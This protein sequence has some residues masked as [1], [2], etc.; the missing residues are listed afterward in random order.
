M[1]SMSL[2]RLHLFISYVSFFFLSVTEIVKQSSACSRQKLDPKHAFNV[3]A[4]IPVLLKKFPQ[5]WFVVIIASVLSGNEGVFFITLDKFKAADGDGWIKL[6]A[7]ETTAVGKSKHSDS[8]YRH[9]AKYFHNDLAHWTDYWPTDSLTY[10]LTDSPTHRLTDSLTRWLTD[11]LSQWLTDSMTQWLNESLTHWLA[12]SLTRWL[13]D[14]LTRWLTDSLTRWLAD[15]LTR[16]LADSLTHWLTDSLLTDSLTHRLTTH[17]L[18]DSLTHWP[19]DPLTHWSTDPLTHW[20]TDPLIMIRW[21]TDRLR[22][23]Q[24]DQHEF[25][26]S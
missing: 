25:L 6:E 10:W 24:T 9:H 26:R 5:G 13:S 20:L 8:Q 22:D 21:P 1:I 11:S 2:D 19:T 3:F 18:T 12:D 7:I 17:W 14:P 4:T 15:S 23:Q 16:W